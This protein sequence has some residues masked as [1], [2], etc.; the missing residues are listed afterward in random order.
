MGKFKMKGSSLYGGLK[1]NRNMDDSSL[2]D[3]RAKSS[4]FQKKDKPGVHQGVDYTKK[5]DSTLDK[6]KKFGRGVKNEAKV[7]AKGVG[8]G[9][10]RAM[11][12]DMGSTP[13]LPGERSIKAASKAAAAE[14]KR[15]VDARKERQ[16]KK[17][18]AP[19]LKGDQHKID[20]NKNGKIDSGDFD[21]INKKGAPMYGKKKGAPKVM[22]KVKKAGR[23]IK[24]EAKAIAKG[25]GGM[26]GRNVQEETR[27]GIDAYKR[28][29]ARQK[30]AREA[31]A[32][33]KRGEGS[34]KELDARV[35]KPKNVATSK[36]D[37]MKSVKKMKRR[38]MVSKMKKK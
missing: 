38:N 24:N 3:G 31:R 28:E 21:M 23:A 32:R 19:K 33:V 13:A 15:Q 5:S 25:I 30:E 34:M 9:L 27:E 14:R 18:G 8:A 12:D 29:K 2:A 35:Q 1:L 20:M 10:K 16:A 22:D 17:K 36:K 37:V 7:V 6:L 4:T 11:K 26:K